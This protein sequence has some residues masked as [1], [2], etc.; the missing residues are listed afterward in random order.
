MPSGHLRLTL[1]GVGAM[2]SPRFA[3][4]G[5]LVE[6]RSSRIMLDGGSRALPTGPID[7]WLLTDDR[8]ELI[9]EIRELACRKGVTPQVDSFSSGRLVIGPRAVIHTA[10]ETFGYLITFDRKKIV[11]APEFL[12]FPDW[13]KRADLM[14]A[15]AASWSRPIF[16]RGKV[17]GHAPVIEVA[18]AAKAHKI[19]RLVFAHIGRP[20]IK[21]LDAGETTS[22]G[23]FGV[24]GKVYIV[25]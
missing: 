25:N 14:F 6:H 4:A 10:H 5:L 11:W 12:V 17:G 23:E 21:M 15:E 19:K 8:C 2:N 16:F 3:P 20:T 9:R 1:T 22:F 18:R 13:A 7:A 24:E